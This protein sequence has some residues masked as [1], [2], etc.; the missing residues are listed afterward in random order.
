M[1]N[2]IF[3]WIIVVIA[4]ALRFYQLGVNPPALNWDEVALGYNAYTLGIDGKD[5]FG[6]LFPYSYIESFGDFKPP[7][8]SYLAVIP[9]KL[10]GLTDFATRF[11]SA[12]LGSLT[13]VITYFLVRAIFHKSPREELYALFAGLLLAISP[14]HINLSRA[15]FEANVSTFF[16]VLGV[17][18]FLKSVQNRP[19]WLVLSAVSFVI[20]IHTFNSAR[21]VV[22]LLALALAIGFRK[23]LFRIKKQVVIAGILGILLMLPTIGFLLS[24]QASLRFK[25]VNIF[26]DIKVVERSNQYI[27]NNNNALWSRIV[28][29]RRVLY[30]IEYVKHYLD[31]FNP[32]FLFIKGDGNPKFSTQDVGQLYLWELPFFIIGFFIL[33][34]RREKNWWVVPIW[35]FLGIIP[36][37]TARETPHALRIEATLP[38]FQIITGVGCVFAYELVQQMKRLRKYSYAI[39]TLG[40]VLLLGNVMY[41]LHGYYYHYPREYSGEWLHGYKEAVQYARTIEQNYDEVHLTQALGRPYIY[42][43]FY[44]KISPDEFR[45]TATVRRDAF[46]FVYIDN[47]GKWKFNEK[48]P[49]VPDSE[50]KILYIYGPQEIPDNVK[51]LKSVTLLNSQETLRVFEL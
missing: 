25:E 17:Y 23:E 38:T 41:Y 3:F 26:S 19:W 20:T 47:V 44:N 35:L 24:P 43:L 4:F 11:P 50:K 28:H 48:P 21:V 31:H 33:F 37:A 42:H 2:N 45:R 9:V 10:L 29:N 7:V 49:R 40:C 16:I 34:R 18:L 27:A 30:G 15:A 51:T 14:W 1:K 46:G 32:Q 39:L 5:E 6:V 8:Y 12:L 36:A 13:V 22:P